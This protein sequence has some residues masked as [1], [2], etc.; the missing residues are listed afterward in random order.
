M[1]ADLTPNPPARAAGWRGPRVLLAP[2]V[3]SR[4]RFVPITAL[5]LVACTGGV[6]GG[7]VGGVGGSPGRSAVPFAEGMTRPRIDSAVLGRDIYS[8]EAREAR[9]EG[10]LTVKC[11]VLADGSIRNCRVLK[12]LRYLSEAWL[13]AS[14][15]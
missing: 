9:I 10:L 12:P 8:L 11:N 15:R 14:S 2:A 6:V 5:L 1:N 3:L 13:T 7:V 4:L